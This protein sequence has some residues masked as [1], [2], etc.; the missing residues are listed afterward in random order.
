[1]KMQKTGEFTVRRDSDLDLRAARQRKTPLGTFRGVSENTLAKGIDNF[2]ELMGKN[3][4]EIAAQYM[5]GGSLKHL[6]D[7]A[8]RNTAVTGYLLGK[9][10][11]DLKDQ[12]TG[13][14]F[15]HDVGFPKDCTLYV[16]Y[17]VANISSTTKTFNSNTRVY[18]HDEATGRTKRSG[19]EWEGYG[20]DFDAEVEFRFVP[21]RVEDVQER[22]CTFVY[23]ERVVVAPQENCRNSIT[24]LAP[25]AQEFKVGAVVNLLHSDGMITSDGLSQLVELAECRN[26]FPRYNESVQRIEDSLAEVGRLVETVVRFLG[27]FLGSAAARQSLVVMPWGPAR[28]QLEEDARQA[29]FER[30]IAKVK[31]EPPVVDDASATR[32]LI[33]GV[34]VYALDQ[35]H[36]DQCAEAVRGLGALSDLVQKLHLLK[37]YATHFGACYA[38]IDH[39]MLRSFMKGIGE[40][41]A[42]LFEQ[43]QPLDPLFYKIG[44]FQA[45]RAGIGIK[46]I[47]IKVSGCTAVLNMKFPGTG[48]FEPV[49]GIP[50]VEK[51]FNGTLCFNGIGGESIPVAGQY[52]RQA[53]VLPK[54]SDGGPMVAM[55]L[56]IDS[57]Y[58]NEP[59]VAVLGT[60]DGN[61]TK[62]NTAF[63]LVDTWCVKLAIG[64][65]AMPSN[66]KFNE[67]M[68]MLP[69][70][71]AEF[72][73]AIRACDIADGGLDLHLIYLRPLLAAKL[74]IKEVDLKGDPKWMTQLV[75]LMR[76]GVALDA[77]AQTEGSADT[78]GWQDVPSPTYDLARMKQ[79]TADLQE[80]MLEQGRVDHYVAPVEGIEVPEDLQPRFTSLSA[81]DDH[82]MD[83]STQYR[84][85]GG[86]AESSGSMPQRARAQPQPQPMAVETSS[87]AAPTTTAAVPNGGGDE[88]GDKDVDAIVKQV[89]KLKTDDRDFMGT[90]MNYCEKTLANSETVLGATLSIPNGGRGCKFAK[91]KVPDRVCTWDYQAPGDDAKW[92]EDPALHVGAM[93][94]E[95]MLHSYT[96]SGRGPVP[97][98]RLAV[99]GVFVE[100]AT[101]L[102]KGLMSGGASPTGN[103]LSAYTAMHAL[104]KKD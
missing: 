20:V 70:E 69:P 78:E 81:D 29:R 7:Y 76:G 38:S 5:E 55:Q 8:D 66:K 50:A 32:E 2:L 11:A 9:V 90:V 37:G 73:A 97:T 57:L 47:G 41:N 83:D 19:T 95:D 33:G 72:A 68:S 48:D 79:V 87:A 54:E 56:K 82:H 51:E 26:N 31:P 96:Q 35:F 49:K 62:V 88:E 4:P 94:I 45:D 44:T 42:M 23:A 98:T 53:F 100:W 21:A 80:N 60:P 30:N 17:K 18:T 15:N 74:G 103:V 71:M 58:K 36:D 39:F 13:G 99:F 14:E 59:V 92:K 67:A 86:V 22:T 63:L 64:V 25:P 85:L 27:P 52:T 6:C 12:A 77:L 91:G 40:H 46:D 16:S 65:G 24:V 61:R 75:G 104:Q 93:M 102:L 89:E 10:F 34:L 101:N 43:K 1:M 28:R 3:S 84:S